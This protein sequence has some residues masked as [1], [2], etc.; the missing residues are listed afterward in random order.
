[1]TRSGFEIAVV[2]LACRFPGA[3]DADE[4]WT[5]LRDGVESITFFEDQDLRAAGV[6]DELLGRPDYVKARGTLPDA[7]LFDAAFFDIPPSEA[8][9]MDPQHRVF[10]ELAWTALEH[11]GH[12]PD[13]FDGQI[14]VYAGAHENGYGARLTQDSP[15][16][17]SLG[18]FATKIGNEKDYLATRAAYKFGLEGPAFTVQTACSTSLVAVHLASQALLA[19]DCDLALAGGVNVYAAQRSGYLYEPGGIFSPDG[20][21]RPFDAGARGAVSSSGGGVVVLR[22][23]EDA[24]AGGDTVHAVLL[25][26]A[27]NNDGARRAGYTAPGV[28]GQARV[29]RSAQ[30][31]AGV[32]PEEIGYVEAHGSATRLGDPIEVAALTRAFRMDSDAT[33]FCRLGSVKGN[34]G[35]THAAA[36][37]AGLIKTVLALRH[38]QIPPSVNYTEPNPEIDFES[39]PFRVND[40]LTEW[41]GHAPLRAGVSSFGLGGANAHVVVEQAPASVPAPAEPRWEVITLSARAEAAL[42]E[43]AVRLGEFLG[44]RAEPDLADA[45]HT[46]R[47]G[48]REFEHRGAVV[49]R[50]RADAAE[51]LREHTPGRFLVGRA[52]DAPRPVTFVFPGVGDQRTGMGRVLYEQQPVFREHVDEAAELIRPLLDAD[53]RTLM[54]AD[55]PGPRR[56]PDLRAMLSR[57]TVEQDD[58]PLIRTVLAHSVTFTFEYALA[59]LWMSWGVRLDS[60]LGYSLGEL[61]AAALAGVFRL[62]DALTLVVERAR[63]IEQAPAGAMLAVP[64]PSDRVAELLSDE[65]WM[66]A[67]E[68]PSLSVVSGAVGAVRSLADRLAEDGVVTRTLRTSQAFHCP[69]LAGAASGMRELVAGLE[70]TP[71]AVPYLSNVTGEW[72]TDAEAVDCD[73]WARHLVEPVRFTR[74]L[75]LLWRTPDRVLLEVGPGQAMTS[76]AMQALPR[77]G[78]G[79]RIAV[80]SMPGQFDGRPETASVLSAAA[81]LWLVGAGVDLSRTGRATRRRRVP[82][83]TYP[84]QRQRHWIEPPQEH[85]RVRQADPAPRTDPSAWFTAPAWVSTPRPP[86]ARYSPGGR[87][88][89][90]ADECGVGKELVDQ[91]TRLRQEVLITGVDGVGVLLDQLA[92]ADRLPDT[93]VHLATVRRPDR[94]ADLGTTDQALAD[95]FFGLLD[96]GRRLA[97]HAVA[98]QVQLAV[99]TS[100]IFQVTGADPV[101]PGNAAVLG[102][103]RVLPLEHPEWTTRCVDVLTGGVSAAMVAECLVDELATP[104]GQQVVAYRGRQR[105]QQELRPVRVDGPDGR[106]PLLR[107]RG[108]YLVVGGFGGVGSTLA[109]FLAD[110]VGA[111]LVLLGRSTLPAADEWDDWLATHAA[112]DRVSS[113]INAVRELEARGAEVLA[114]RADVS[115]VDDVRRALKLAEERFGPVNGVVH[116]AGTFAE[117]LAQ[118]KDAGS[119]GAVLAAKARGVAVLDEVLDGRS[120]DFLVLCSSTV[121]VFGSVG[122]VDYC[123]ANAVLDAYAQRVRTD[124]SMTVSVNWDGWREVGM[125]V[126]AAA[127]DDTLADPDRPV[128]RVAGHPLLDTRQDLADGRVLYTTELSPARHWLLD[129]HRMHGHPVLAGTGYLEMVF[130]AV[131][132]L[133]H[134]LPVEVR[135]VVFLTPIVVPVGATRRVH[136]VLEPEESGYRLTFVGRNSAP[137]TAPRWITHASCRVVLDVAPAARTPLAVAGALVARP[138][139]EGPLTL[140]PRSQCL[141]ELRVTG[142]GT[143]ARISLAQAHRS[144]L[145]RLCVHP[146]LLDVATGTANLYV[147]PTFRVP[148]SYDSIRVYGRLPAEF[149]SQ[150]R[151]RTHPADRAET[152]TYDVTIVD[153]AGDQLVVVEGLVMKRPD[154]LGA[155]LAALADGSAVD[156]VGYE[157]A[158]PAR[159]PAGLA[160]DLDAGLSPDD[161]VAA[162]TRVLS[163]DLSPQ[164]IVTRR[165]VEVIMAELA[166]TTRLLDSEVAGPATGGAHSRPSLA[167]GYVAPRNDVERELVDQWQ[168]LLG[169]TP[170]GVHDDFADLGGHSLFGVRLCAGIRSVYGVDLSLPDLFTAPTPAA[171]AEL[172]ARTS[173]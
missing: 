1:M 6:P 99:V 76:A 93:I 112:T 140:G 10:L 63:L 81:R 145:P 17:R 157:V 103:C 152:A 50:D 11:G 26:S 7:E 114:V 35:H 158:G 149:T 27:I 16:V 47:T 89:V 43:Q 51:V 144:D 25:G 138:V 96:I 147:D 24:L 113:R 98:R 126:D 30:L 161:G 12:S 45:A 53:V 54:F 131:R 70:R 78:A 75:D 55:R 173:S 146:A 117:G 68:A 162:F 71:P 19:G 64:L 95:G 15:L 80:A 170:I 48:R 110:S 8:A 119:A 18:P 22:R 167:T 164:V 23:L 62:P 163:R 32:R 118:L 92:A 100:G 85:Q 46:L 130:G 150:V 59:R 42:A 106:V 137:R 31:A 90:V 84:F 115:E 124:S 52:A 129:E 65:V 5:N 56:G 121:G 69:L 41:T 102:P 160:V 120:L 2:G 28:S 73:Y 105:W 134:S 14:G 141:A 21:C 58:D 143:F 60:M 86:R 154:D 36:G 88:L 9:V 166:A 61:T 37:V 82:L 13:R 159:A 4:Y 57:D 168:R 148:L 87:W 109:G 153:D 67:E 125:V 136:L 3:A 156:V 165:P 72:I 116:A 66:A 74:A 38:R 123:A 104:A 111:R 127:R 135:D 139:H 77:D 34:I 122:Q 91:L 49:A 172:I 83:P 151:V 101:S 94:L 40:T 20:H 132:D 44:T 133:G 29:I 97:R 128:L 142:D 171:L 169:I 33:G 108:V 79:D 107:E 39:S 155:R